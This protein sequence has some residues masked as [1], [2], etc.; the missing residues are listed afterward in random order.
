LNDWTTHPV[1][2]VTRAL[3][4]VVGIILATLVFLL[5]TLGVQNVW[6]LVLIGVALA[7]TS[8]RAAMEPTAIRLTTLAV[9]MLAIPIASQLI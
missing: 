1:G 8:V 5:A 2:K 6:L 3:I 4:A 7:A 9:T